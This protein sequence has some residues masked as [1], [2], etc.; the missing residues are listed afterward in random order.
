M[1]LEEREAASDEIRALLKDTNEQLNKMVTQ[2]RQRSEKWRL[3]FNDRA[4][5]F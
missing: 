2:W 5:S 4:P 1:N 3:E